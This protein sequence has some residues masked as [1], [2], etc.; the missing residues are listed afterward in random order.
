MSLPFD[1]K[2]F[3]AYEV[4]FGAGGNR[5]G[6]KFLLDD[7]SLLFVHDSQITSKVVCAVV[8]R[9]ELPATWGR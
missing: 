3:R 1:S 5:L 7:G 4:G 8:S 2:C 6:C 9:R